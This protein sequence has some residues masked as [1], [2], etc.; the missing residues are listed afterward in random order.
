[1]NLHRSSLRVSVPVLGLIGPIG[2]GKSTVAGWLAEAGAAIVD[3]DALTR[4]VMGPGGPVAERVIDAFGPEFRA[5][6]GSLDRAAL[7]RQ[8]FADP[9]RLGQLESIVHPAV[10]KLEREAIRAAEQRRPQA[11]VLEA[12]RLVE[13]GHAPWCDEIWLVICEPAVQLERLLARGMAE[14]DARQRVAAQASSMP[15]WRSAATRTVRTDGSFD[16][17]RASV[18]QSFDQLLG[19]SRSR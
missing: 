12:I 10:E 8:V 17:V 1:M 14:A 5:A 16:G 2:C 4:E 7:G 11:I 6:D 13:A 3:A 9:R 18:R 15:L 19:A